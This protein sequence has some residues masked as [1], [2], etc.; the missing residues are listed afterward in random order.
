MAPR[1]FQPLKLDVEAFIR[2]QTELSGTWPLTDLPRLAEAGVARPAAAA[3]IAIA[4][5]ACGEV[6]AVSGAAAELWMHLQASVD[7]PFRCQRCLQPVDEALRV[8]RWIRFV[9]DEALAESLDAE[10]EDDIL[11]LSRDLDLRWLVEDELILASPIVPRHPDCQPPVAASGATAD[12]DDE[13]R[14]NPF[15]VLARLKS[16]GGGASSG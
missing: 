10:S 12:G 1:A 5:A 7:L 8:D 4:W 13:V 2:A 6:R 3:R 16:P 15:G 14:E 11:T 9:D